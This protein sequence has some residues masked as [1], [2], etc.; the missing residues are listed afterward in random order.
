MQ[1]TDETCVDGKGW[2]W[3]VLISTWLIVLPSG[4]WWVALHYLLNIPFHP[5]WNVPFTVGLLGLCLIA[6]VW[7]LRKWLRSPAVKGTQ[8]SPTSDGK[9]AFFG[10]LSTLLSFVLLAS[11]AVTSLYAWSY[12]EDSSGFTLIEASAQ[13]RQL[14]FQLRMHA[15]EHG[16]L[17][18][19]RSG[20]VI[21]SGLDLDA[22]QQDT[23]FLVGPYER[24]QPENY[25]IEVHGT[26]PEYEG[27]I[28]YA[29]GRY[30]PRDDSSPSTKD[31]GIV[32]RD[33][34]DYDTDEY[35]TRWSE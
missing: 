21:D 11:V 8:R 33:V 22:N 4:V 34:N 10:A 30:W 7:A 35:F 23:W 16:D 1:Q 15:Y 28:I 24:W 2:P 25:Y 3:F 17:S 12:Q 6:W 13:A 9:Q 14:R 20:R 32:V 26:A 18:G 19:I 5:H 29:H 31:I 27:T